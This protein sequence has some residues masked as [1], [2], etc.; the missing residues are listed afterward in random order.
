VSVYTIRSYAIGWILKIDLTNKTEPDDDPDSPVRYEMPMRA[1]QS[2]EGSLIGEEYS[3][4][5]AAKGSNP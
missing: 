4:T 1:E 3:N 2:Q 5:L